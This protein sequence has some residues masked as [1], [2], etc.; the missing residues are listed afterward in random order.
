MCSTLFAHLR[1]LQVA[2]HGLSLLSPTFIV[3]LTRS[4]GDPRRTAGAVDHLTRRVRQPNR[5]HS[6]TPPVLRGRILS[7]ETIRGR[8]GVSDGE[9]LHEMLKLLREEGAPVTQGR[10]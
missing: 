3:V 4:Q 6:Q 5:P 1:H 9:V 2:L 8:H 7:R 10:T